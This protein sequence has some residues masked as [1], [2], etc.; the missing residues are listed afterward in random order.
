MITLVLHAVISFTR[1]PEGKAPRF[2]KKPTIRQEGD[3]LILECILEA[4]PFPEISWFLGNKK[5]NDGLRHRTSKKET[6]K[7]TYLLSLEIRV[8]IN[9]SDPH[10]FEKVVAEPFSEETT[11]QLV[12]FLFL[13]REQINQLSFEI[14]SKDVKGIISS[15]LLPKSSHGLL[16]T[17]RM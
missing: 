7:H 8:S 17:G 1:I 13:T 6:A 5:I 15:K 11:L 16:S 10:C 2:P 3:S 9:I 4:H 14:H 12:Q